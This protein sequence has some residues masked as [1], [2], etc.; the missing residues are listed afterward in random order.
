MLHNIAAIG[1]DYDDVVDRLE[2]E[3]VTKFEASSAPVTAKLSDRPRAVPQYPN[4]ANPLPT[5][6]DHP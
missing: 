3:A 1:V 2:D 4:A 6:K 5:D